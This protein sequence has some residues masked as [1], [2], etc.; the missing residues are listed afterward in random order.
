MINKLKRGEAK[1]VVVVE[2][3]KRV[4]KCFPG[5]DVLVVVV[6]VWERAV[7]CLSQGAVV[8]CVRSLM[9][10]PHVG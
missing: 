6:E 3:E 1:I 7:V 5:R 4:L 2:D 9:H 10:F 8:F